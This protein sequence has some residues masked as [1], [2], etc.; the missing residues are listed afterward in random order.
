MRISSDGI[1][2]KNSRSIRKEELLS[3]KKE[4]KTPRIISWSAVDDREYEFKIV[5][6]ISEFPENP[7]EIFWEKYVEECQ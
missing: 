4:R 3:L 7:E 2:R 1:L 6:K 5:W